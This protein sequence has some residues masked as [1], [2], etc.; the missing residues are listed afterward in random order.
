MP[1]RCPN[2]TRRNKKTGLC[3][4]TKKQVS[5]KKSPV[6]KSPKSAKKLKRCP[7]G[8]HRNKKT[9]LCHPILNQSQQ[10]LES[11]EPSREALLV[12]SNPPFLADE[13][14]RAKQIQQFML[15]NKNKIRALFLNTICSDSGSCIALGTNSDKIK[16]FFGGFVDF[17]Y[18]DTIKKIGKVSANGAVYQFEYAHRNYNSHAILKMNSRFGSDSLLYEYF[19]GIRVNY[20]AKYF[21]SFLE[22][23][24][25]YTVNPNIWQKIMNSGSGPNPIT[26]D[27]LKMNFQLN[28]PDMH[29]LAASCNIN[30][31][32]TY[33][34][35][36]QHLKVTNG[37]ETMQDCLANSI[38]RRYDLATSLYQVYCT[39]NCLA[40]MYTHYD[41]HT[42]NV[43]MYVPNKD[44][45]IQY[46]YHHK[47][48]TV[49]TFKSKYIVKIIDYGRNYINV[50][51]MPEDS[52]KFYK[53]L[54]KV[55]ECNMPRKC[56]KD[57]GYSY[58]I[59]PR[60]TTYI[61]SSNKNISHDLRLAY[62]VHDNQYTKFEDP[63]LHE[64]LSKVVFTNMYGTK[65][66]KASGLPAHINN[67]KDMETSLRS[68]ITSNKARND[69]RY[70]VKIKMGDLHVYT[71]MSQ[72]MRYVSA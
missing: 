4:G 46:H 37:E 70:S 56:G 54:C 28:P 63:Q 7:K 36:I 55:A 19:V 17:G 27:E 29:D 15:Q 25:S 49:T 40:N 65:E 59:P 31:H 61:I 67:V 66:M 58:L 43:M 44:K 38:F 26:K 8:T 6:Q 71:D 42:N 9:G 2:G 62:I 57:Y 23:Y 18:L 21:P 53:K 32:K 1:P 22:T 45:Y 69:M 50:D 51:G 3:E 11:R 10:I 20:F 30:Y 48:G 34:I 24:G 35:L 39:L 52:K 12:E 60:P 47:N 14:K 64:I 72:P 13:D 5:V 16:R 33:A 68:Y 41:L